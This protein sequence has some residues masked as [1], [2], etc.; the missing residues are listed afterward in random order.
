MRESGDIKG[1]TEEE[2]DGRK[3]EIVLVVMVGVRYTNLNPDTKIDMQG[4]QS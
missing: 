2:R 4:R 3:R 1:I